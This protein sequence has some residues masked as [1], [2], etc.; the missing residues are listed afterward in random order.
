[1]DLDPVH[2][3]IQALLAGMLGMREG[4]IRVI[5]PHTGGG[6]GGKFELDSTQFC[7]SVLSM[8][9]CKPVKIILSREE[10][11]TATKRRIPMYYAI[12]LVR[13]KTVYF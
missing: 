6:F 12:K 8:K 11:F 9:T 4:D 7:S 1:M 2:Y 3:Y 13:Q 5:K 10:E